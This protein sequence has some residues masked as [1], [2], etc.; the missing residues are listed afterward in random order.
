M[1]KSLLFALL[2]ALVLVL[3]SGPTVAFAQSDA[4]ESSGLRATADGSKKTARARIKR[5]PIADDYIPSASRIER[6]DFFPAAL[7]GD[8]QI[9]AVS[10]LRSCV[11]EHSRLVSSP[12]IIISSM[13]DAADAAAIKLAAAATYSSGQ[14]DGQSVPG[15]VTFRAFFHV[16]ENTRPTDRSLALAVD[17]IK[18]ELPILDGDVQITSVQTRDGGFH[19]TKSLWKLND[20]EVKDS[21]LREL[22]KKLAEREQSYFCRASTWKGAFDKG[23]TVMTEFQ[24][25]NERTLF[26]VLLSKNSCV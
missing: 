13:S 25:A 18:K 22:F 10:T 8:G 12:E 9:G 2:G 3:F 17:Q 4:T 16:G 26:F 24:A 19:F 20:A 21:D 5:L 14:L 23:V 11:D 7:K 15:C 6:R 1:M